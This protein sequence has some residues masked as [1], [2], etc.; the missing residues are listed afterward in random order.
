MADPTTLQYLKSID[1]R[2]TRMEDRME[3][4]F[5]FH[6]ERIS[7]LEKTRE[8]QRGIMVAGGGGV[9]FFSWLIAHLSRSP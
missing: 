4:T 5:G 1:D 7:S 3:E 9:T 6:Q 2:T 8:R